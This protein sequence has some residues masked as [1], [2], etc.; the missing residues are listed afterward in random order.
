MLYILYVV[1]GLGVCVASVV[2]VVS[3]VCVRYACYEWHARCVR[4]VAYVAGIVRVMY[5]CGIWVVCVCVA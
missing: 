1:C 2:C 3:V 4:S 5:V